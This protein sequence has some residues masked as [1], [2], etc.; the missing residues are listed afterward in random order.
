M[1]GFFRDQS[2][3][4]GVVAVAFTA[5]C[6]DVRGREQQA[7]APVLAASVRFDRG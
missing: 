3:K 7:G 6:R 2:L 5:N 4:S 1:G